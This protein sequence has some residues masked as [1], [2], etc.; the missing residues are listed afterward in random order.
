MK[1]IKDRSQY[2]ARF[3][4]VLANL[5]AEQEIPLVKCSQFGSLVMLH[6]LLQQM[7]HTKQHSRCISY[8][9]EQLCVFERTL[10]RWQV[11]WMT[12]ARSAAPHNILGPLSLDSNALLKSVYFRLYA[13]LGPAKP[14]LL[15]EEPDVAIEAVANFI[16]HVPR[17]PRSTKAALYA[18]HA[19]LVPFKAGS[20]WSRKVLT[21]ACS[22]HFYF[23]SSM[24]SCRFRIQKCWSYYY[25]E[26]N[27]TRS[28]PFKMDRHSSR[29]PLRCLGS[30]RVSSHRPDNNYLTGA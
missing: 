28:F 30:G 7:W 20:G 3:G 1:H 14:G 15:R 11:L 6:A 2:S 26:L 29:Q 8:S 23:I 21:G 9:D 17:S 5:M 22:L 4:E 24:Q 19:L 16:K 13:G 12:D 27:Y 10:L 18:V 25:A